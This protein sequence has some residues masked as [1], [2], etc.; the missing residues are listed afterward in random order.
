MG[1]WEV[2]SLEQYTGA[3]VAMSVID[4]N[5]Q[6]FR[7]HSNKMFVF[8][9][10]VACPIPQLVDRQNGTTEPYE[11][12]HVR[13]VLQHLSLRHGKQAAAHILSSGARFLIATTYPSETN[14]N[15]RDG[16]WF[17]ANLELEPFNFPKP[18]QCVQ[19]HPRH[20]ADSTCLYDLRPLH[21]GR[22]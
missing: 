6:R 22:R 20:E 5:K 3:D 15:V 18:V 19:T 14:A 9:D 12:L 21:K 7:H 2:D 10:F 11:L 8:H 17:W 4:L 13:D 16:G 1:A